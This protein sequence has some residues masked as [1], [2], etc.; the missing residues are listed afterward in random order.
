MLAAS[1]VPISPACPTLRAVPS[2]EATER[3]G[4]RMA[5]DGD[6]ADSGTAE[7]ETMIVNGKML[8]RRSL[9]RR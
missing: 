6:R 2:N 3:S 1:H 9:P 5:S 4:A 7:K 8:A